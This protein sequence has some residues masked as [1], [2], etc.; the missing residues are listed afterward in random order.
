MK[1]EIR[2]TRTRR[3]VVLRFNRDGSR[4]EGFRTCPEIYIKYSASS[5]GI[6]LH[7][8]WNVMAKRGEYKNKICSIRYE[9]ITNLK[10]KSWV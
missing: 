6:C 7:A 8:L 3:V 1:K 5:L 4:P 10:S 9:D 2:P